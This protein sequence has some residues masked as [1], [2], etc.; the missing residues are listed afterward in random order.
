MTPEQQIA[1]RRIQDFTRRFAAPD[2]ARR[3]AGFAALPVVIS[4]EMLH[5]LRINLADRLDYAVEYRLL[6]SPLCRDLGDGLY[7]IEPAVRAELLRRLAADVTRG[8]LRQAAALLHAYL[9]RSHPW[10]AARPVLQRAQELTALNV[11]DPERAADWLAQA[12]RETRGRAAGPRD[13][14]VAMR[15][16]IETARRVVETAPDDDE[17]QTRW[18][19]ETFETV[20]VNQRGQIIARQPGEARVFSEDLG[21][22]VFLEMV[23]I[24][25]GTFLMG[26]PETEP[27]RDDDEGPQHEVTVAPFLMGRYPVTQAQWQAVMGAGKNPSHFKGPQRPVERVTWNEAVAFCEQLSQQTGRPFRLPSEAEWEYA[28][29]AGTSTPFHFGPTITTELANYA[30]TAKK[31]ADE[32]KG[33]YREQTT[34][35]GQF[36]PNA[37]GLYDVHGNVWEWCA[38]SWYGNYEDAPDDGSP[39]GKKDDQKTKVLRGGSW[40]NAAGC[41]RA[42]YR[43]GYVALVDRRDSLGFRVVLS[44]SARTL[45]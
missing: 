5:L 40:F 2:A 43:N 9:E 21:A 42:A 14:F 19:V 13:W 4:P 28:G 3:L 18:R 33:V 1:Q 38:D 24:P 23:A 6:L 32:P 39:R 7:E 27:G 37:F 31:Y 12:E 22:G 8:E 25:G 36:P 15:R 34:D 35:A 30:G 29:R 41:C 45:E 10:R 11:L 44:A 17:D 16:E 20:T 26:S